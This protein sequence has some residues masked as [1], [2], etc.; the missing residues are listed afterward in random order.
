M[1]F[2]NK[3]EEILEFQ[4]TEYGKNLLA[5][6]EFKPEFY[7]FYD[8]D[9]QYDVSGSGYTEVQNDIEARIQSETPKLKIIRT[10][11]GAETRVNEFLDNLTT[12]IGN[13]NSDPADN[14]EVFKTQQPFKEKGKLDAYAIGRSS[15]DSEY[16]P[17]WQIEI[18]SEPEISSSQTYTEDNDYIDTIPQINIDVDY[19][20]FFATGEPDSDPLSISDYLSNTNIHVSMKDNYLMMEVMESN[21]PFEKSNFEIEVYLSQS[22]TGYQQKA[23]VNTDAATIPVFTTASV[24]YYMNVLVDNEIPPEIIE[25]LSISDKAVSTNASRFK[26][27][28]DIYSVTDED[29]CD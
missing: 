23:F 9:V 6:G 11:T 19:E 28:R 3:K 15:L 16:V 21:T 8:D 1:E 2:F 25:A 26:L 24:G 17:A 20:T 29:I 22:T 14:V 13:T 4:L 5:R 10:R 27:N 12:A 7:A 18:L